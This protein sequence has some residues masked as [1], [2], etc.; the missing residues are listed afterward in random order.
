MEGDGIISPM[1][2]ENVS[3][4]DLDTLNEEID[5]SV[6][7]TESDTNLWNLLPFLKGESL[8]QKACSGVTYLRLTMLQQWLYGIEGACN[9]VRWPSYPPTP[10]P[11]KGIRF[12]HIGQQHDIYI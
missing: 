1:I 11:K 2:K 9:G 10:L 7:K 8:H 3:E 5:L 4:M 12:H 6:K